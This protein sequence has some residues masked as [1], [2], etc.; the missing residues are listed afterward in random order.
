MIPAVGWEE[1]EEREKITQRRRDA[2]ITQRRIVQEHRQ[3][4][5]CNSGRGH[6]KV[7]ATRSL[8]VEGGG[9]FGVAEV[10]EH[11]LD[12]GWSDAGERQRRD[13][14]FGEEVHCR[15]FEAWL[16]SAAGE[17]ADEEEFVGVKGIGRVIV[18]I[19]VVDGG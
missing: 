17:A 18:E 8:L 6:L 14:V 10:V 16:G 12:L 3:E 13:A 7:A 9:P 4:C 2:E 1:R 5:L 15:G 19:M 11:V